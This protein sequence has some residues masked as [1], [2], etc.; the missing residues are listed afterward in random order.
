M[1]ED[2]IRDEEHLC[3]FM[4]QSEDKHS[5][6]NEPDEL[7]EGLKI[8]RELN[9]TGCIEYACAHDKFYGA[10]FDNLPGLTEMH[11]YRLSCLGWDYEMG[12]GFTA[13]I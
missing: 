4:E 6:S 8:F 1:Y 9:P 3:E 2:K 11:V 7:L 13:N 12:M 5:S 10:H